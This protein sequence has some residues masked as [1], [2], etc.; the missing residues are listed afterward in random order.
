MLHKTPQQPAASVVHHGDCDVRLAA[1]LRCPHCSC[2]LHA[3][4]I[5]TFVDLFGRA[6]R[7]ICRDCHSDILM[8]EGQR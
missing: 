8:V 2:E 4:D 7:F 6:V 1:G 5:D 3:T